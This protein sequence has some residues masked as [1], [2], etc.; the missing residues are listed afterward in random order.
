MFC[1][2]KPNID[3]KIGREF[4]VTWLGISKLNIWCSLWKI[5]LD[6]LNN[7]F[8]KQVFEA[9]GCF[10]FVNNIC[11]WVSKNYY[12]SIISLKIEKEN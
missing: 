2:D 4:H 12:V 6:L 11:K 3:G 9:K 10:W 8:S 1:D 7:W 5:R